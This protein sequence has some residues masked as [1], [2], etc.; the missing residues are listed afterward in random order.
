MP[1]TRPTIKGMA[2]RG[3]GGISKKMTR[4]PGCQAA[5]VLN[6]DGLRIETPGP[7]TYCCVNAH[8]KGDRASNAR[9]C[10]IDNWDEI[11]TAAQVARLGTISA[12]AEALGVH[13]ATV[14]RHIDSLEATLGA[15]LFQR[16]ARGFST[17][18][19][20]RHL[21][22]IAD[23]TD[24]QFGELFRLARGGMGDLTGAF[25]VTCVD[26]LVPMIV[27]MITAFQ[28][29]HS[30]VRVHLISSDRVLKLEY[31]EADIAFRIGPKPEHPDN[32]VLPVQRLPVGLYGPT[33]HAD[34][35][36]GPGRHA[37]STPYYNW[38]RENV[39]AEQIVI[40]SDSVA[41]LWA[42]VRYGCAA[43]F[44]LDKM[45][46]NAG[47]VRLKAPQDDWH[48]Q[49]WAVTHVDL[50]RSAKVQAFVTTMKRVIA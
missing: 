41:A 20:G 12:A 50:H 43:G 9:S 5:T 4:R 39:L 14:T 25:T 29:E 32:V 48:E 2:S 8:K 38:M 21:L 16:H 10:N 27:P 23:A 28:A 46:E 6:T 30:G 42:A 49:I 24:A 18:E 7:D 35:F 34:R 33:A 31:G 13:R 26:V 19:L 36:A 22:R 45:A 15:K 40:T 47:L 44:M 17:T 37:P 11:R 3:S 1:E